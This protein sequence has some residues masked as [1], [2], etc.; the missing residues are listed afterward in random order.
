MLVL[1]IGLIVLILGIAAGRRPSPLSPYSR[2]LRAGGTV[3]LL[4]WL[5]TACFVQIGTGEIGVQI[6]FGSVQNSI[7]PSGLHVINPLVDIQRLDVKS[8]IIR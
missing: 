1:I 2:Y 7:L 4:L 6:L 3:L 8:K 5:L